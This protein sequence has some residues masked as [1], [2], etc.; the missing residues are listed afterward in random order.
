MSKS[1]GVKMHGII[2]DKELYVKVNDLLRYF[3]WLKKCWKGYPAVVS[4]IEQL[5]E[6]VKSKNFTLK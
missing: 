2:R 1:N 3:T 5:R 6:E 4:F